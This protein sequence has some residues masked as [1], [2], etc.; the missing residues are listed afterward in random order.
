MLKPLVASIVFLISF[1]GCG[2][3]YALKG[4]QALYGL[5]LNA[6]MALAGALVGAALPQPQATNNTYTTT[7]ETRTFVRDGA[8]VTE[9]TYSTKRGG[10]LPSAKSTNLQA[11]AENNSKSPCSDLANRVF[12]RGCYK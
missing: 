10:P 5:Q 1:C 8:T 2:S 9:T 7:S 11:T 12:Y 3:P 4:A 6:P